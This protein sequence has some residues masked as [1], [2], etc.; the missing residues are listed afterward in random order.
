MERELDSPMLPN[1]SRHAHIFP[2]I[3]HSLVS[4]G[5]LYDAGCTVTFKLKEVNVIYKD[6]IIL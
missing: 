1:T 3:R 2:N 4:I 6:D 5:A